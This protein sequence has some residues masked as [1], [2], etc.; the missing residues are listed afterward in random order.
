VQVVARRQGP[1]D[2]CEQLSADDEVTAM[3]TGGEPESLANH[4]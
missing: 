1:V 4:R 2:R 3:A